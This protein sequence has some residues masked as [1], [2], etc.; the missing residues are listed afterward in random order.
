M[1]PKRPLDEKLETVMLATNV[2]APDQ[3]PNEMR[4][5]PLDRGVYPLFPDSGTYEP[6]D[7]NRHG[8]SAFP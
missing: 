3:L 5:V 6:G 8:L 1:V 2:W 7:C 4:H